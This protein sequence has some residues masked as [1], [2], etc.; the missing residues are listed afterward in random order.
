[1][2][3][4]NQKSRVLDELAFMLFTGNLRPVESVDGDAPEIEDDET[5]E[6]QED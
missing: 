4:D 5:T 3:N 2:L 6:T 1:M